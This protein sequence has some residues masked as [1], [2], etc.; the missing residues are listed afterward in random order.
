MCL[1]LCRELG[2]DHTIA[3]AEV[4]PGGVRLPQIAA[5]VYCVEASA[6]VSKLLSANPPPAPPGAEAIDLVDALCELQEAAVAADVSA[7]PDAPFTTGRPET[8][9]APPHSGHHPPYPGA[10]GAP[11]APR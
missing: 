5:G 4:L 6:C 1:G 10:S 11:A 8:G 9:R 2:V 3:D 7:S